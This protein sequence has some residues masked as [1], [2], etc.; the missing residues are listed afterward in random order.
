MALTG[1]ADNQVLYKNFTENLVLFQLVPLLSDGRFE[2]ACPEDPL[3]L[4]DIVSGLLNRLDSKKDLLESLTRQ[5]KADITKLAETKR[6]P[7]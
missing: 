4:Q 5:L 3:F 6:S 1:F 7:H 2:K